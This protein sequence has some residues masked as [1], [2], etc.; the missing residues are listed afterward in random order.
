MKISDITGILEEVAPRALQEGYDN[1]GLIVGDPDAECDKALICLDSTEEIIDEAISQGCGL[2]IAHHP[3]VFSGLKKLNGKNYVERVVMKAIKHDI[4][5]YAIHTN[6]DN[7]FHRGVNER[8]AEK[9]GLIQTGILAP[10][11]GDLKKLTT[12][13]PE[14][15]LDQL[16]DAICEAGAGNIGNYDQC[17]FQV[18]GI[19]TF[20]PL[21]GSDPYTGERGKRSE[22]AEVRIEVIYPLH[23]ESRVLSAMKKAHPYEEVAFYSSDLRNSWQDAGAGMIGELKKAMS[24]QDFLQFLKSSM[25]AEVVRFTP[26][27]GSVKRV[28]VC[29]G[30]GSFLLGQAMAQK[31]DAFVTADFKYHQ[32]FDAEGK[33]MICDIG[34]YESEQFTTE[35]ISDILSEKIPNFALIFA[36]RGTNPIQYY[37]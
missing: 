31:A 22:E 17:T 21:E 24:P 13:V 37:Y 15:H 8:I 29:G 25:N 3:I 7:V 2:V 34:H 27:S 28:A 4:A 19:G 9:L 1:S 11:S 35:L 6:L 23:S 12:F 33:L 5:I 26:F 30:S 18:K 20:R 14:T 32:F 10:R 16:R 36:Q